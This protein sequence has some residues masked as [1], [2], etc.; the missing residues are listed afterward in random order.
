[1]LYVHSY[2]A[3]IWNH[4]ASRRI[5]DQDPFN[6]FAKPGDLYFK[7]DCLEAGKIVNCWKNF[8]QICNILFLLS[9]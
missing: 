5:E 1:M 7:S 6:M 4:V 3:Y 9:Y 8:S 2:Q